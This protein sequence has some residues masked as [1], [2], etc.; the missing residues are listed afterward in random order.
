MLRCHHALLAG[1]VQQQGPDG[2]PGEA[3]AGNGPC[4]AQHRRTGQWVCNQLATGVPAG[5]HR[6][7]V[8]A[9][10]EGRPR[11]CAGRASRACCSAA[12]TAPW[13]Q[14]GRPHISRRGLVALSPCC[15]APAGTRSFLQG[16]GSRS[17]GLSPQN[18]TGLFVQVGLGQTPKP[19]SAAGRM[20]SR[21]QGRRSAGD[22]YSSRPQLVGSPRT[23]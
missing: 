11:E 20:C 5:A 21:Q 23:C 16:P 14:P 13:P 22:T 10:S 1:A 2:T 15:R 17:S 12:P 19:A 7:L 9:S 8:L 3:H 18:P 4:L 6:A